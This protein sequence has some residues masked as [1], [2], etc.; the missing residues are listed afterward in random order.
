MYEEKIGGDSSGVHSTY[1]DTHCHLEYIFQ[2]KHITTGYEGFLQKHKLPHNYEG[3]ISIFCDPVAFSSLG[4]WEN[5]LQNKGVWGAFGCHPH[6]AKYYNESLK[7]R[8]INCMSHPKAVA[9]GETGLDYHYNNSPPEVQR[10]A[11]IDQIQCAVAFNK[12]LIV[13]SRDAEKDTYDILKGYCPKDHLIHIHCFG[14]SRGQA[15]KLLKEFPNLYFG[16]TGAITYSNSN[17]RNIIANVI[18]LERI[19]L[20][21]D[22]PYMTPRPAQGVCHPGHIPI[23]AQEIAALKAVPLEKLYAVTRQN[24]KT[25]YNI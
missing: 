18:P 21:T 9:W 12:P 1:I 25:L 7:E 16:F 2:K 11:F 22:A 24:T 19:V 6:N 3:C 20:E 8:I 15:E 17:L 10:S 23:I 4:D 5:L 13:H 14:D